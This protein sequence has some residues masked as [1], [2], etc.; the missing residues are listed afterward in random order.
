MRCLTTL[1]SVALV[2]MLLWFCSHTH[3]VYVNS[4]L[5]AAQTP[6]KTTDNNQW[7]GQRQRANR[8]A[9]IRA[10][11]YSLRYLSSGES[12]GAYGRIYSRTGI[13]R[14]QVRRSLLRFRS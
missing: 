10:I 3:F 6:V 13:T 2:T 5:H 14:A 9:L 11:D 1:S 8:Q 7:N 4:P 12:A